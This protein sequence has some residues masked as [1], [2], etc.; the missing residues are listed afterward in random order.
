MNIAQIYEKLGTSP[1]LQQHMIRV[2]SVGL[3]IL[4]NWNGEKLNTDTM[5]TM[6]L[7]HDIGNIVKFDLEKHPE[8]LGDEVS[9][10][11]YWMKR[12]SEAIEKYGKD[13]HTATI[14][15]LAELGV[16]EEIK[17]KIHGMEY[18]D[19]ENIKDHDD[20]YLKVALYD[21]LRVGPFGILTLQERLDDL[22]ARS[23]KCGA[24]PEFIDF[25]KELEKQVQE[26]M[27]IGVD[28]ISDETV[29]SHENLRSHSI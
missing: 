26:N 28:S 27:S 24:H 8:L 2:T 10:I 21:D 3:F 11:E 6:L 12:Q 5:T 19:V 9:R 4:N 29:T 22:H 14:T 16:S 15:M 25:S 23:E 7:L 17:Q 13:D 20:W 1:N 18:M